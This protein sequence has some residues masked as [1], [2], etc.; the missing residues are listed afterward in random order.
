MADR[1]RIS[2]S[3]AIPRD[4][5]EPFIALTPE[6]LSATEFRAAAAQPGCGDKRCGLSYGTAVDGAGKNALVSSSVS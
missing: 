3:E 4:N 5:P 1:S 6:S 2:L